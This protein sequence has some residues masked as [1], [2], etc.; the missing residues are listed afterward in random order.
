MLTEHA[1]S[2]MLTVSGWHSMLAVVCQEYCGRARWQ[3]MLSEACCRWM[4][5]VAR[6]QGMLAVACRQCMLAVTCW[7][8]MLAVG[9]WQ[10]YA[11]TQ[12]HCHA[13][14]ITLAV[15]C[16]LLLQY[17]LK[18]QYLVTLPDFI[19]KFRVREVWIELIIF[20]NFIP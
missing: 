4:L 17:Q 13:G 8:C 19:N 16:W 12:V 6:W 2:N 7:Q 11:S 9:Y 1:S 18:L 10:L 14:S 3:C 20:S 15:T 5:E